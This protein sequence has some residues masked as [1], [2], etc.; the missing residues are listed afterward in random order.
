MRNH[1]R[2][3][4]LGLAVTLVM[5]LMTGCAHRKKTTYQTYMQNVLDV[6]YKGDFNGYVS[7]NDGSETEASAM[8]SETITYL[9][10]QLMNHY[11]LGNAASDDIRSTFED[12]ARVIYSKSKYEVSQAYKSGDDYVVD[13][14]VY[15]MNI[16]NQSFDEIFA[17]IDEYNTKVA[18]GDYEDTSKEDYEKEFADGIAGILRDKASDMEYLSPVVVSVTIVDDGEYYSADTSG[19][20][21]VDASMLAIE[22]SRSDTSAE[23][24]EADTAAAE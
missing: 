21:S 18:N 8:Y 24:A 16:L 12:V 13:V 2:L 9:A 20:S 4:I 5:G 14:T 22:G 19:L 11:S 17:Y 23:T 10:N 3:I 15:P 7:D 6:N 1:F